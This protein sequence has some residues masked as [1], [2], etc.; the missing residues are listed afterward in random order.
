MQLTISNIANV[1][2]GGNTGS[3]TRLYAVNNY[4]HAS[5]SI[6]NSFRIVVEDTFALLN[7]N[8]ILATLRIKS[9]H[10]NQLAYIFGCSNW[11]LIWAF[12]LLK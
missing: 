4:W 3:W 8:A 12:F 1:N 10:R 5:K 7:S 6:M 2:L 11:N 9:L